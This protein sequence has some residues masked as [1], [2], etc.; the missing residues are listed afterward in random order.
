[1]WYYS[2]Y[3]TFDEDIFFK[4]EKKSLTNERSFFGLSFRNHLLLLIKF[5][6]NWRSS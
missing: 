3:E 1:V 2:R 6:F 4:K 5:I